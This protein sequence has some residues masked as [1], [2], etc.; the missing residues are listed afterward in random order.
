MKIK[1]E[2][3][4]EILSKF[5]NQKII[6][7]GDLMLDEF[8][9]GR[10]I[11]ISPEAPVPVLEVTKEVRYP[12]GA[13]NVARNLRALGAQVDIIGQVGKDNQ[14]SQLQELLQN[15]GIGI[16]GVITNPSSR[17]IVKTRV[18]ARQQQMVRVDR[19]HRER[20]QVQ[21]ADKAISEFK[22]KIKESQAV[23][24]EDYGKGFVTQ[25]LVDRVSNLVST[26]KKILAVD[27][28]PYNPL[29]W[30]E[31]TVVK[32]NRLEAF[33]ASGIVFSEP[34]EPL[35]KDTAL[36]RVGKILLE[37]WRPEQLLVTL[38]DQGMALFQ[39]NKSMY[40]TPTHAQEVFDVTGAGDTVISAYTLALSAGA[41]P[42]E[43]SEIANHA[44]G[45]V[46]EK[47]GTAVANQQEIL[48]SFKK[49]G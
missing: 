25:M 21:I 2:R 22:S 30:H 26:Q 36:D 13:A 16:S 33:A 12:G 6:V 4:K 24:I 9:Y 8:I 10:V 37:K 27:P 49:N 14:A 23:I 40:H 5:K 31:P 3:I 41:T 35:E 39:R 29:F 17:T 20:L 19:E 38:G 46:V 34:V 42:V 43:A 7:L 32:P 45:I 47:V 44:A 18:I 11:R 15:E 28:N 1:P 48:E